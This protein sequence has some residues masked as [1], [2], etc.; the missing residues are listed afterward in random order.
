MKGKTETLLRF[1][2]FAAW[3]WETEFQQA[4]TMHKPDAGA[5]AVDRMR[6]EI[7]TEFVEFVREIVSEEF[8][9]GLFVD[10]EGLTAE[11]VIGRVDFADDRRT[12]LARIEKSIGWWGRVPKA[13]AGPILDRLLLCT[14]IVRAPDRLDS[15][16]LGDFKLE[17]LTQFRHD[18]SISRAVEAAHPD[19][20]YDG[21][22]GA[23][24]ARK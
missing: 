13:G 1:E 17:C 5:A 6:L 7:I 12:A 15:E 22:F 11:G 23:A 4:L 3:N 16:E 10:V 14:E 9:L 24:P 21:P 8:G 19:G 20:T 2:D 18:G